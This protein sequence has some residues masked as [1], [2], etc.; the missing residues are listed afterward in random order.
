MTAE[1]TSN[2]K[3]GVGAIATV[4]ILYLLFAKKT[5]NSGVY[6]PAVSGSYPTVFNAQKV[7]TALWEAMKNRG[8]E[9]EA[10]LEVLKY[11]NQNQFA[12]VIIAFGKLN[13]NPVTGDQV[14]YNPFGSLTKYDLKF[15]LKEELSAQ[16][17]AILRSKYPNSL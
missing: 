7:A 3:L 14:N 2:L 4:G 5:D 13:Y 8:T 17:Y 6:D 16:E 11:V 10:I 15:W 12:Q 1:Q 9:E